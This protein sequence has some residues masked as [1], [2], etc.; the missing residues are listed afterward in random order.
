MRDRLQDVRPIVVGVNGSAVSVAALRWAVNEAERRHCPVDAVYVW[1]HEIAPTGLTAGEI[2]PAR[3]EPDLRAE[4]LRMLAECVAAIGQR[5]GVDIRQVVLRGWGPGALVRYADTASLLVVGGHGAGRLVE[6]L[7]G[8]VS[9]YCI[10]RAAC[11]VVVVP[12]AHRV[13]DT[14]PVPT[15]PRVAT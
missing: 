15:S 6:M 12:D 4:Y 10:R 9:S 7:L 1:Q 3:P 8:T 2:V 5:P 11:P 13:P 14:D